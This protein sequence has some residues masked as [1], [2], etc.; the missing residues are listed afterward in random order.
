[1]NT[2][3]T[4]CQLVSSLSFSYL[5]YSLIT[6]IMTASLYCLSNQMTLPLLSRFSCFIFSLPVFPKVHIFQEKYF[7]EYILMLLRAFWFNW[8]NSY[9]VQFQSRVG[10]L[11][12]LTL[13]QINS[14]SFKYYSIHRTV[15]NSILQC[16]SCTEELA[17]CTVKQ[18]KPIDSCK[19]LKCL[20]T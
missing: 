13:K 7:W 17:Y 8:P 4:N 9:P 16:T 1:M 18:I 19:L 3:Q 20:Q 2:N 6:S 15:R 11:R 12:G 5:N 10:S 14:L